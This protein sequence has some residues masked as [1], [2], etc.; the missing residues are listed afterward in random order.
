MKKFIALLLAL[1]AF[2][3]LRAD[4]GI[5]LNENPDVLEIMAAKELAEHIKLATNKNVSI[6][7]GKPQEKQNI[8]VGSHPEVKKLVGDKKFDK[9]EYLV[10]SF[11][12]N[13]LVITGGKPRGLI[14]AAY[15][16][17]E[18]A[19]NV[20]WLD[21]WNTYIEK[22]DKVE[23][24]E[25]LKI[26]G[27]PSF[28]I[29]GTYP[30][31][32]AAKNERHLY[33]ARN[34]ANHFHDEMFNEG[35]SWE[36]GVHP[37]VGSPR[38]CHTYFNYTENWGKDKDE[39]FSLK[40]SRR[41]RAVTASGPGQI[42]YTNPEVVKSFISQLKNYIASDIKRFGK[43]RAPEIYS[44]TPNDNGD[45]C[46]CKNCSAVVKKYNGHSGLLIDFTNKLAAA[47]EDEYPHVKIMTFA[48]MNAKQPPVGITPRKNVLIQIALL[49]GEYSGEN[50]DTHRSFL[51]PS[52]KDLDK[53]ITDWSKISNIAIWDYWCLNADRDIY[54][55]TNAV[56]IAET[57]KYY[58]T[59][60]VDFIFAECGSV[61][62][63]A[64][65]Q[66]R[67]WLGLRAA[68]KHSIDTHKEIERFMKAYYGKAAPMMLAYHDLLQKG[69]DSLAGSL[70]Y[71]P[72]NRRTDL[73]DK[74][75]AEAEKLIASALAAEK[76]NAVITDRINHELIPLYRAKIDKRSELKNIS[77]ADVV[78][79]AKFY[80]ANTHKIIKKYIYPAKQQAQIRRIDDYVKGA[81]AN[82]PPLKG[83]E[84]RTVIADY[85]WPMLST[86]RN[87]ALIDD[88]EAAGGKAVAMIARTGRGYNGKIH[89]NRGIYCGVYDFLNRK[90]L[91]KSSIPRNAVT[92]D[93]QYHWYY[94][95]R[96]KVT[97]KAFLWMHWSWL[98]QQLLTGVYDTSG[99]N[100]DIDIFVHIKVQGAHHVANSKKLDAYAIDR[101][102]ICKAEN[103]PHPAMT[104]LPDELKDRKCLH[105]VSLM[106]LGEPYGLLNVYDETSPVKCALKLNDKKT[107][108]RDREL[109]IGFYSADAKRVIARKMFKTGVPQDEKFHL[110]SLGVMK[111]PQKGYIYVHSSG[112]LRVDNDRFYSAA[113]ADRKYE[114]VVEYKVE[115]PSYVK[116]SKKADGAYISRVF[117][118]E[119]KAK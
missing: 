26:S 57:M 91:I 51:H 16:F 105:E 34:R 13:T 12:K 52:N 41:L 56:N 17:L 6:V 95:G 58:K 116:G 20:V 84:N 75:F 47:V 42:C 22:K 36:R 85:A 8:F 5:V 97:E 28:R 103:A 81:L 33:H 104:A 101:V 67:L 19:F 44:V 68:Y 119:P 25:N 79:M 117:F 62:H 55:A 100:N 61:I 38:S 50:R 65:F 63:S 93:E 11:G 77:Q 98:S 118:L 96:I 112:Y 40:G 108:H 70:C 90:H 109:H 83:F 60:N 102:V 35:A 78:R 113:D 92:Q 46:D 48:Y 115:G 45:H 4:V 114:V 72:L 73:N 86:H 82:V 110:L 31:F 69:N 89:E 3:A 43:D 23:W 37:M 39:W 106:A 30:Y 10:Q 107:S 18:N 88:P 111:L 7:N 64:F 66:L 71:L 76:G 49:G 24:A 2:F 74:F 80:Q 53:L 9:E 99:L 54:P 1:T 27:K 29:R 32:G 94:V 59:K 87:T 15:E 14:Y 21:E